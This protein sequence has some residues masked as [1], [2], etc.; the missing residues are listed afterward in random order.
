M[1]L[2]DGY[3]TATT[4]VFDEMGAR[5]GLHSGTAEFVH[6]LDDNTIDIEQAPINYYGY[7]EL[8]G[9]VHDHV[10]EDDGVMEVD[11][12]A[13]DQEQAKKGSR[14]KNYT[15]LED[16]ILI[17]ALKDVSLDA[18]TDIDQTAKRRKLHKKDTSTWK[19]H[20]ESPSKRGSLTEVDDDGP[21]NKNKRE[22][23]KKAKDKIKRES[24][25]SSLRDKIDIMVQSNEVL[26][27][28]TLETKKE[29]TEK[30]AQEKLEKCLLL[31]EEGL[32]KA[33]IEERKALSEEKK[34]LVKLLAEENKIMI[35]N[36]NDMDDI[37]K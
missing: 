9:G 12:A 4:N 14:S 36:H 6:L 31:K 17:K 11:K 23:N 34:T 27:I 20:V 21:R 8:D 5:G 35:M 18:T 7:N 33:A 16:Q 2:T 1:M 15:P 29:L 24:E 30:K 10:E 22:G 19:L 37:T 13:F 32:R 25:A 28:K 26:V 3:A